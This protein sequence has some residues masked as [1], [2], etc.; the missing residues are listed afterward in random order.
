MRG[1]KITTVSRGENFEPFCFCC[2][3]TAFISHCQR[4]HIWALCYFFI[5]K[6]VSDPHLPPKS[7][8][9]RTP[10]VKHKVRLKY[11]LL[12]N[13]VCFDFFA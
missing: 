2:N 5:G 7:E 9:A 4:L 11:L 8:F 6:E 12:L 3:L 1:L 10:I 13:L